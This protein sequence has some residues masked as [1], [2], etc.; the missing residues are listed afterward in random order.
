MFSQAQLKRINDDPA[1]LSL[2]YDLDLLPEQVIASIR[3]AKEDERER[4]ARIAES[5]LELEGPMPEA[6]IEAAKLISLEDHLRITVR[7]TKGNIAK[8]IREGK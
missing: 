8:R 7:L 6:N 4:C 5:E 3:H 1:L 2:L